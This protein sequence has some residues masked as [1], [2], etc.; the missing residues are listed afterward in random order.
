MTNNAGQTFVVHYKNVEDE[1]QDD[2]KK[3][4]DEVKID[5][6]INQA[7]VNEDAQKKIIKSFL[8]GEDCLTGVKNNN[9]LLIF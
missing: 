6:V 4:E 2:D 3:I 5:K 7:A 8:E 9:Y 1:S